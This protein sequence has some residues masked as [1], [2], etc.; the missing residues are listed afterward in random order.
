MKGNIIDTESINAI[1]A[2]SSRNVERAA[3]PLLSMVKATGEFPVKDAYSEEEARQVSIL[4]PL[5]SRF[6]E[7]ACNV[8]FYAFESSVYGSISA[9]RDDCLARMKEKSIITDTGIWSGMIADAELVRA[10]SSVAE[11]VRVCNRIVALY[12]REIEE[13]LKRIRSFSMDIE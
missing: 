7:I 13:L 6:V 5:F 3:I 4:V 12:A 2:S 8:F 10:S 11:S 9:S 1:I